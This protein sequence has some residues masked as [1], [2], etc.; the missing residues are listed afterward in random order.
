MAYCESCP[1]ECTSCS[2]LTYFDDRISDYYLDNNLCEA[3]TANASFYSKNNTLCSNFY[4]NTW[5]NYSSGY[6]EVCPQ[7]CICDNEI[8]K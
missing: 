2:N 6:C 5:K 7:Y 1:S 3:S 4:S 8:M